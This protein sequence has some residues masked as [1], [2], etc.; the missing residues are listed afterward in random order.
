[1][2][3]HKIT[4]F[5]NIATLI[6]TI[7]TF[8]VVIA[9]NGTFCF[10]HRKRSYWTRIVLSSIMWAASLFKL[11]KKIHLNYLGQKEILCLS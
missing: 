1:M 9:E 4:L 7:T 6:I 11:L 3:K 10:G 2:V 8:F 5:R